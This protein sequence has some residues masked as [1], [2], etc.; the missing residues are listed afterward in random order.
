M[1]LMCMSS[2]L[3]AFT[4]RSHPCRGNMNMH[5]SCCCYGSVPCPSPL[6]GAAMCHSITPMTLFH[7]Q[8]IAPLCQALSIISKS[9]SLL[10]HHYSL[11]KPSFWCNNVSWHCIHG[12]QSCLFAQGIEPLCHLVVVIG[13]SWNLWPFLRDF[14][15]LSNSSAS[16]RTIELH[17][18]N[19]LN[20]SI[21]QK[22]SVLGTLLTKC[23]YPLFTYLSVNNLL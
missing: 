9:A 8:G 15:L 22:H 19:Q 18:P 12:S 3:L 23:W 16:F 11:L 1:W 13:N 7:A 5:S 14:S 10:L 17:L 21:L 2:P 6:L 4:S 20:S